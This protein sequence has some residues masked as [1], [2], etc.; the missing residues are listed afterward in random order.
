MFT[1]VLVVGLELN[2]GLLL[3]MHDFF[4][5]NVLRFAQPLADG[6]QLRAC[7]GA[8]DELTVESAL[9]AATVGPRPR[10]AASAWRA[11]RARSGWGG[12]LGARS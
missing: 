3:G 4:V 10:V 8:L 9:I 6:G 2:Y 7:S 11:R 5:Y 1:I 12:R